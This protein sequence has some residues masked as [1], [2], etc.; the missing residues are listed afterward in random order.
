MLVESVVNQATQ[1]HSSPLNLFQKIGEVLSVFPD[2]THNSNKFEKLGL[3]YH[4]LAVQPD[5]RGIASH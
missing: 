3:I 4:H 1:N 5:I 2:K